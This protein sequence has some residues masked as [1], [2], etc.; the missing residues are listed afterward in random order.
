MQLAQR[1]ILRKMV[2]EIGGSERLG[3]IARLFYQRMSEDLMIGFFFE[4]RDLDHIAKQ[5]TLFILK[6][7]GIAQNASVKSPSQAHE[8]LPPILAG[9]FD[10]R[11]VILRQLLT[12]LG[13]SPF[14]GKA[15]P[16]FE[17][18]FRDMIVVPERSK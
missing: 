9:H 16:E 13:V 5:Q 7:A 10:R 14:V 3:E 8:E 18:S 12:E 15:W 11:I 17:V 2:E 1:S 6:A 4:G